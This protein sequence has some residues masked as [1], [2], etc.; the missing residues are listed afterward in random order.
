MASPDDES[1]GLGSSTQRDLLLCPE[2]VV[3]FLVLDLLDAILDVDDQGLATG[4]D[5]GQVVA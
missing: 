4:G 3:N 2:E 5:V 1:P